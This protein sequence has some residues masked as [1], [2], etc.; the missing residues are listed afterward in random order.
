MKSS[1]VA[2]GLFSLGLVG[3]AGCEPASIDASRDDGGAAL[4]AASRDA[5]AS[6]DSATNDA[7]TVDSDC[8]PACRGR[9]CGDDGCGGSCGTCSGTTV[10]REDGLCVEPVAGCTPR[11]GFGTCGDDGCGG[12][13]GTCAGASTC[14]GITPYPGGIPVTRKMCV[15]AAYP[16]SDLCPPPAEDQ[17]K[18]VGQVVPDFPLTSCD[19]GEP[20][21][22]RGL[23]TNEKTIVLR[24]NIDCAPCIEF[25]NSTILTIQQEFGDSLKVYIA[26][27]SASECAD[28][29]YFVSED[30]TFVREYSPQYAMVNIFGS[31]GNDQVLAMGE[32]NRLLMYK[33]RPSVEEIR[34]A[35][36]SAP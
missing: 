30:L 23:C 12:S 8:V 17:G 26:L 1:F 11:C 10:C 35:L 9:A 15:P 7:A 4:D 29:N 31:A 19:S 3:S 36:N 32:G 18:N 6:G 25:V 16:T 5:A 22:I 21:N 34:A 28:H 27:G 24:V 33:N 13:C 20:I 2:V 14:E